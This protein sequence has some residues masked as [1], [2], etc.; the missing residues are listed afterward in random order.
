MHVSE[1]IDEP[2]IR[3]PPAE[4][5]RCDHFTNSLP[6]PGFY[7]QAIFGIFIDEQ[8]TYGSS[9]VLALRKACVALQLNCCRN[10]VSDAKRR[11]TGTAIRFGV[12]EHNLLRVAISDTFFQSELLLIVWRSCFCDFHSAD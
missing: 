8:V 4:M 11:S 7:E 3:T 2:G 10:A 5:K 9:R 12:E 1:A 6:I